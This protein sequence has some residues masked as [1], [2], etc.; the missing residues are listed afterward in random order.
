MLYFILNIVLILITAL[1][2]E[3]EAMA[4]DILLLSEMGGIGLQV[5]KELEVERDKMVHLHI[6]YYNNKM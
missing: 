6:N 4:Q 3:Q 5:A 1:I 2:A